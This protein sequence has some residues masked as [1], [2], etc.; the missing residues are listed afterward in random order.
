M[1]WDVDNY[2]KDTT[3]KV[4]VY[5]ADGVKLATSTVW[6]GDTTEGNRT[7]FSLTAAY[8]AVSGVGKYDVVITM[9]DVATTFRCEVV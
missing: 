8:T 5:T 9:G 2:K 7:G 4:E 3:A 6:P 1:T